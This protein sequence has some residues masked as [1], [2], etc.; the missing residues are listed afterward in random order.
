VGQNWIIKRSAK[1]VK[2]VYS[3]LKKIAYR[4]PGR[5]SRLGTHPPNCPILAHEAKVFT[6]TIEKSSLS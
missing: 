6:R 4:S 2:E 5:F 1:Q 3:A